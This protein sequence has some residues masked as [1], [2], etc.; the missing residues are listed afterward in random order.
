[1][2]TEEINP[3]GGY[4]V[5]STTAPELV[6]RLS[7]AKEHGKQTKL[8]FANSNFIV[9]CRPL[10]EKMSDD[11]VL[12]VNDGIAMDLASLMVHG[13]RFH[14][15]LNGTDFVPYLLW[16]NGTPLRIFMLGGKPG[17]AS[18]AGAV[19]KRKYDHHI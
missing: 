10:Q 14:Q 11:S 15:N 12:I 5:I 3:V 19:L 6:E 8:F 18:R 9:Q 16:Q 7:D 17:V 13:K 1:M 4:P 2:K